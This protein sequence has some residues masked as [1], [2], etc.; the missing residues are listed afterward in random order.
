MIEQNAGDADVAIP[1]VA[2]VG[3]PHS[4]RRVLLAENHLLLGTMN[5]APVPCAAPA[6]GA[7]RRRAPDAGGA[8]PR[9]RRSAVKPGAAFSI[10]D[11][12]AVPDAFQGVGATD[13]GARRLV[14][15]RKPR[16]FLQPIGG[17]LG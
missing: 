15:R 5:G 2:K 3:E 11:D 16:V 17:R 10:G 8:A 7:R 12:L 14:L 9:A 6:C 13:Q 1:H 4:A